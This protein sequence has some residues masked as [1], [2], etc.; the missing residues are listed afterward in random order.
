MTSK[1]SPKRTV[2][3][4]FQ[5]T[6]L[7]LPVRAKAYARIHT[8]LRR[9]CAGFDPPCALHPVGAQTVCLG[10]IVDAVRPRMLAV[11]VP[12]IGHHDMD[13]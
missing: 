12:V 8:K 5:L 4:L 2:L 1:A 9:P 11:T 7:L 10:R 6:Q 13:K 3:L